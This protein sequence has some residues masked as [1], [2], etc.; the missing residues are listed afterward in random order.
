M[1]FSSDQMA[2]ASELVQGF[3]AQGPRLMD[4]ALVQFP[5]PAPI[6]DVNLGFLL[7]NDQGQ[8]KWL[9]I[10]LRPPWTGIYFL[11]AKAF[12]PST[13]SPH[14]GWRRSFGEQGPVLYDKLLTEQIGVFQVESGE[15]LIRVSF[16]SGCQLMIELFTTRPN[17]YFRDE[18]GKVL[19]QWRESKAAQGGRFSAENTVD[20]KMNRPGVQPGTTPVD[21]ASWM[22]EQYQYALNQRQELLLDSLK[23]KALRG[24]K[25]R[26]NQFERQ[27]KLQNESMRKAAHWPGL[28]AAADE[29]KSVMYTLPKGAELREFALASGEMLRL[30]PKL[31]AADNLQALY[32]R[33]KKLKRTATEATVRIDAIEKEISHWRALY[34]KLL[35][36]DPYGSTQYLEQSSDGPQARDE[37][38]HEAVKFYE[39]VAK[40][41]A[42]DKGQNQKNLSK[43]EK[44][45][46]EQG[47]RPFV[48]EEG[49][50]IWVGRNHKENEE[51]V[52]RLANGSDV[53]LHLK[54]SPG[55][56]GVIQ[57]P[58]GRTASLETLLDAAHLVAHYSKIEHGQKVEVDYTFRKNVKRTSKAS[59]SQKGSRGAFNVHYV[60]NKSLVVDV[61]EGR[62]RRL[63]LSR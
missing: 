38:L 14:A 5:L 39:A 15:R 42:A 57:V 8:K 58:R 25:D 17:W 1:G 2:W 37:A 16:K 53:W 56:H 11:D 29:F 28:Q 49:L 50:R 47:L 7:Q 9:V 27:L 4:V 3:L 21:K 44:K 24:V 36:H 12:R 52:M 19:F 20:H 51:I 48:S 35:R 41:A 46:Q 62:I 32:D 43:K 45:I 13:E 61:D 34:S 54:G 55:A 31:S 23:E 10:A 59:S 26:L 22:N 18:G 60:G 6:P 63:H 33:V 30:D 40:D